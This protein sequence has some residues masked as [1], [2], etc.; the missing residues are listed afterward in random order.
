[1][2]VIYDIF[3]DFEQEN[4]NGNSFDCKKIKN[5]CYIWLF[6]NVLCIKQKIMDC[7]VCKIPMLVL[8]LHMIEIDYCP[9]CEGIWLDSGELE[10]LLEDSEAKDKLL[11]S[12][13][14]DPD[15]TERPLRCPVCRK[16]MNKVH[17]GNNREVLIDSCPKGHGY[18]FDKGELHDIVKMGSHGGQ[19][20]VVELL[21]EM[22]AYKLK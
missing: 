18:W 6:E 3:S 17:A 16:K 9:S 13:V 2:S 14:S 10:L 21:N 15:H 11:A 4:D 19:G 22:F 20:K 7:P 8:E 1:M 5:Y 12:F